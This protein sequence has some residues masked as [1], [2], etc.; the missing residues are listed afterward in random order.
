MLNALCSSITCNR[1]IDIGIIAT[2]AHS[3]LMSTGI[4]DILMCIFLE[5]VACVVVLGKKRQFAPV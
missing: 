5:M 1:A 2:L 3:E 4:A